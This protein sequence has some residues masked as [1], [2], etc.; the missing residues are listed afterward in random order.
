M[1][2]SL[3]LGVPL[4]WPAY[5]SKRGSRYPAQVENIQLCRAKTGQSI[6]SKAWESTRV[7]LSDGTSSAVAVVELPAD[8]SMMH[9]VQ[10]R[11]S[12]FESMLLLHAA[13]K[14]K[15]LARQSVD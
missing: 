5:E 7:Q 13:I 4:Q 10:S 3:S 1:I 9:S 14:I 8:N 11:F 6:N 12:S 2:A 15:L